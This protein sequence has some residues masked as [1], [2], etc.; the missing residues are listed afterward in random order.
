MLNLS[1]ILAQ[2]ARPAETQ[3]YNCPWRTC[4]ENTVLR[5]YQCRPS[6]VARGGRERWSEVRGSS[7]TRDHIMRRSCC[8]STTSH[9]KVQYNASIANSQWYWS[10]RPLI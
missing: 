4:S 9:V 2:I 7:K 8:Y 10:K 1:C 5:Q 3:S 6:N